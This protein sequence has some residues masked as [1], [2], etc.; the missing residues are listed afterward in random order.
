[1]PA[2]RWECV[3]ARGCVVLGALGTLISADNSR[4][5][6]PRAELHVA[7]D[8]LAPLH[9]LE[10]AKEQRAIGQPIEAQKAAVRVAEQRAD[11]GAK[12][13][14]VVQHV[15]R[16]RE[17][18]YAARGARPQQLVAARAELARARLPLLHAAPI[19]QHDAPHSCFFQGTPARR[20]NL[21]KAIATPVV[22]FPTQMRC[23]PLAS[24]AP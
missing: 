12:A 15:A 2:P 5:E 17:A 24:V 11:G 20:A 10:T 14:L 8:A 16:W 19:G 3:C 4:L 6:V 23:A 7:L 18:D 22:Y 21:P 13:L 1:M 9:G